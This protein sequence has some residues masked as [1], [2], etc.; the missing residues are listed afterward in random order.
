LCVCVIQ[1]LTDSIK[2]QLGCVL[3]GLP[4]HIEHI[5]T[6][7]SNSFVQLEC[8]SLTELWLFSIP[9]TDSQVVSQILNRE[10]PLLQ[11]HFGENLLSFERVHDS[12]LLTFSTLMHLN[13]LNKNIVHF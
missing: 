2:L 9:L 8:G 7:R 4:H 13:L 1:F 10:T 5:H 11:R 12:I 3:V 6:E